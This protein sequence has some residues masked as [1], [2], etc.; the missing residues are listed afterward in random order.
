MTVNTDELEW[1]EEPRRDVKEGEYPISASATKKY[2]R[3]PEDFRL[4]YIEQK[5]GTKGSSDYASL[6]TAVH[7]IIEET[8]QD[9]P[10][11]TDRPNQLKEVMV[12]RFRERDLSLDDARED[13]EE[14]GFSCLNV[15]A[16]YIAQREVNE[17]RGIEQ[18]F[19]F[20]LKRPDINHGMKGIMDVATG[21]EIWDWKTGKN[22]DEQD[23]IIQGMIY[24]MGYYDEF[25]V[26]PQKVRFVYLRK[27]TERALD[28][29]DQN[30]Q[31]MLDH[32]REV[33]EAKEYE[34][35]PP[36][37]GSQC[38]WCS[39]EGWCSASPVGAG[40]VSWQKF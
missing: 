10:E 14:V 17:W 1:P 20:G 11:L 29:T 36:N 23:E 21:R 12:G 37:P 24:A 33:V 6:G 13:L 2:K 31:K 5:P 7:E 25:G 8:L 28:P 9:N 39:R 35:Y 38:Y 27:E 22:V 18:E 32:V 34:H 3:C 15:A 19:T 16:R 40:A 30:W 4:K 26:V